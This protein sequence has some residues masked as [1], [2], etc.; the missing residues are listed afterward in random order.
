MLWLLDR[1]DRVCV[2]RREPSCTA[3]EWAGGS[4][5]RGMPERVATGRSDSD[6]ERR[7]TRPLKGFIHGIILLLE[8]FKVSLSLPGHR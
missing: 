2:N 4:R 5:G 1:R 7:P 3:Y 8:D 6:L